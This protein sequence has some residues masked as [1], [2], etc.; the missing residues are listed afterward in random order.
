MNKFTTGIIA[1]FTLFTSVAHAQNTVEQGKKFV[2]Y[3]KFKSAQQMLNQLV[4]TEPNND[5]AIYWL[6]QS[7]IR[8]DESTPK[9]WAAAKSIYQT[10]LSATNS[11]LLMAGIG[12]IELLEGKL[13]DARNHFEAAISLSQG[14][15]IA[16]LNAIGFANGNPDSKNG[17]AL[18]AIDK[19]NQATQ[20]KKFNDPDVLVNLGDAWRKNDNGGE[21]LNAYRKALE[22]APNYARADYRIGKMYQ[23]QGRG[24]ESIFME[25]YNKAIASDPAFAPVYANLVNY[26]FETDVP[27]A[28]QYFEKWKSY[29]DVDNK[30]CFYTAVM[31]YAQ[32]FFMEAINQADECIATEGEFPYPNLYGVKANAYNRLKD[33]VRAI[34]NFAQ[35]FKRQDPAKLTSG[36]YIEYAKNLLKIPGNETQ[37]GTLVDQAVMMDSVETNKVQYLKAIATTYEGKKDYN[38]A[39][40]WYRK[41]LL[42]KKNTSKTDFYNVGYNFYRTGKFDSSIVYFTLFT[43]KF[44]DDIL[45]HFMIGK[46]G[47][48]IDTTLELGLPLAAFEKT[49]QIGS[50]DSVKYK[51]Q[52]IFAYKYFVAYSANIKKD[53]P[54]ALMYIDKILALDPN[55]AEAI[56]NK[57]AL[58][59]TPKSTPA[60]KPKSAAK[61]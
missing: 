35:Y 12:H 28:A 24:Q 42:I 3:E 33:S 45:G 22:I 14:K 13:Q 56:A 50:A 34:E 58:Q 31:K 36:D 43:Q 23:S 5:E 53:K 7:M 52:L 27:K 38:N 16:V 30:T 37:A 18:Y 9:D 15:N 40:S 57:E 11:Q 41:V 60:N 54:A 8:S 46:S 20:I 19:L 32:G 47:W 29:A 51:S 2:L 44:P 39:A 55:D 48:A 59:K 21:A 6:G 17:D 25:Y 4:T 1:V 49:I 10:K 61:P 26:Y